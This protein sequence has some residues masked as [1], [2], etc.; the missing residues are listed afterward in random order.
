MR[1]FSVFRCLNEE[2]KYK[3]GFFIFLIIILLL[4]IILGI[5]F[6]SQD[7]FRV[8]YVDYCDEYVYTILSKE[9]SC[10]YLILSRFLVGFISLLIVLL[11][12]ISMFLIPIQ[13]FVVF[14]RGFVCGGICVIIVQCFNFSGV[15]IMLFAYLPQ[16]LISSYLLFLYCI[17]FINIRQKLKELY[18]DYKCLSSYLVILEVIIIILCPALIEF[19]G[20]SLII[21]NICFVI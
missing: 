8:Y 12:S 11:C 17:N 5:A 16:F 2:I 20:V 10:I 9:E 13:I 15:A 6:S 18:F 4:G 1:Y 7:N 14:Y 3:K 19:I 21:R